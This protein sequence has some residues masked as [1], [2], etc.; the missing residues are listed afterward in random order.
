MYLLTCNFFTT[1]SKSG[2]ANIVQFLSRKVA[3]LLLISSVAYANV[4]GT[5]TRST[6][7]ALSMDGKSSNWLSGE[8]SLSETSYSRFELNK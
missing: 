5:G 7:A 6:A 2:S 4:E 3:A 1:L 8:I